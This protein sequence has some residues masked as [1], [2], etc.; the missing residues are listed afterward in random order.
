MIYLCI[1]I[2]GQAWND[3]GSR[4]KT[5]EFDYFLPE[6]LIAQTPLTNRDQSRLL[7]V[8]RQERSIVH[9]RFR[10]I[11]S[12]VEP[13]DVLV[14]NDTRV[15]PARLLGFRGTGGKVEV[16][17][18]HP[19]GEDTWECLVKPG[20]KIRPGDKIYVGDKSSPELSGEVLERTS[21][22]GRVIKWSYDG[23][24]EDL[25][26]RLGRVPLPPYIKIPLADPERYQTVYARIPGSAAAPT[27]GLHFTPELLEEIRKKG[28]EIVSVTLDVGLGTFRPVSE[29]NIEEHQMHKEYFEIDAKAANTI[30]ETKRAGRRV[31]AVGTTVVRVLES[32]CGEDGLLLPKHDATDLFIYPGYSF[33]VVDCLITNFHLP[34]STLLMLVSAFAGKDLVMTAYKEAVE[35]KYRFFSFGDAMLIV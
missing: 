31:F 27:A 35:E 16:L 10:D 33:K 6:E 21:F 29:E 12:Y 20:N 1:I 14:V 17:L 13:G 25:L 22:G 15:I 9:R 23:D 2:Q 19:L 24:W 26:K 4:V 18:L 28:V 11:I 32:S 30:N 34:K 8:T 7:V 3:G 5:E